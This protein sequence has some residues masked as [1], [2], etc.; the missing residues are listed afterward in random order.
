MKGNLLKKY[1]NNS[2]N[3]SVLMCVA[4]VGLLAMTS[5]VVDIGQVYIEKEKLTNGIDAAALAAALELPKDPL[6]AETVAKEY[7]V[8][9]N[10]DVENVVIQIGIDHKSIAIGANK[11]VLH[12]FAGIFGIEQSQINASNKVIVGPLKSVSGGIR[13]FAVETFDYQYG[14]RVIL[15]EGAG[16]GYHGN[17]Y[18][19]ALGGTGLSVLRE[20]VI[21]GYR[22]TLHIGD[23]INTEPG[24]MATI[25]TTIRDVI[26]AD[27]S[28]FQNFK[29]I[30]P[31]IWT[32]PIVDS[33]SVD[34]SKPVTITAFAQFYIED[35]GS[36]SGHAQLTGRFL[37]YV[38]N[39]EID[40]EASEKGAY[41]VKLIK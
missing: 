14:D 27:G 4:L 34:G 7:L 31:R 35:V 13:P 3:V 17:Y 38:G 10:I 32:I 37:Q 33:L 24:N 26:Q 18:A 9:N 22:G 36:K 21:N 19:V 16:D 2:G 8:K 1:L 5:Y 29:R 6:K 40:L 28:T 39:G 20:N 30:S 12:L 23:I 41:G 25:L 11:E 15:K